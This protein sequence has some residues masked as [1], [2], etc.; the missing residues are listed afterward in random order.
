[1]RPR[2]APNI[3][4]GREAV[5]RAL[6]DA[7]AELFAEQ[8]PERVS[9]RDLAERAGVNHGLVHRHFGSKAGV[10]RALMQ[11]LSQRIAADASASGASLPSA[12]AATA[13]RGAY[14]RVLARAL[15]D[16]GDPRELQPGFP[17]VQQLLAQA[18]EAQKCGRVSPDVDARL[19]TAMGVA[20][21]L[22]WLL[23][24]PFVIAATG[25]ERR[26]RYKL[27]QQ[28]QVMWLELVGGGATASDSATP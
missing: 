20:M 12:F 15:L 13:A 8:G 4:Y 22:G 25:L 1:M 3:P 19:L 10:L 27:R 5:K 26:N 18:R 23:F 17:L 24:E 21:G 28:V 9:V 14:W 11:Q 7:A 2:D 16:G 6:L